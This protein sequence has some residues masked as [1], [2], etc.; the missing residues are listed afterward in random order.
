MGCYNTFI[1]G[2]HDVQLKCGPCDMACYHIGDQV[3]GYADGLY[4][5]YGG[6]VVIVGG[7]FMALFQHVM[8]KWGGELSFNLD[9]HNPI[10]QVLNDLGQDAGGG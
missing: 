4:A 9:D 2:D 3:N 1:D 10:A 6:I 7:R 5:G 8:D